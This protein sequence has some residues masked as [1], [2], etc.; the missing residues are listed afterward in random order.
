MGGEAR[1]QAARR[2]R[3]LR[4]H[5]ARTIGLLTV[6]YAGYYLCRSNLSVALPEIIDELVASGTSPDEARIHLGTIVS[7][8]VFAYAVGKLCL[9]GTADLLGGR[10]NF[11][12]GMGGAVAF[13]LLF[14]SGGGLPLFTLAWIGN[15]TAQSIGWAGIVKVTSRWFSYSSYGAVMGAVSL[16]YLFG[17][18]LAR[19]ALSV[20]IAQGFGWR[21]VFRFAAAGLALLLLANWRWLRESRE[22]LGFAPPMVH[23]QSLFRDDEPT[24]RHVGE[25]LRPLLHDRSFWMVCLL[26]LGCTLLRETFNTWIP[27]Y[28]HEAAGYSIADAAATSALFPFVGGVSVVVAG[29]V[30]DRLGTTG[31]EWVIVVGLALVTVALG[32]LGGVPSDVGPRSAVGMVLLVAFALLGPY[33]YLAG[34]IALELGGR[35]GSATSSAVIDGVGYM[36]GVLAGDSIARISAAWGWSGAFR[37]LAAVAALSA[38]AAA[39]LLAIRRQSAEAG[40]RDREA[41][42][43]A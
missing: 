16:S 20:L 23:P 21:A 8:G 34:A 14:A 27:T 43:L 37:A 30:G 17:D 36:G 38:V 40:R 28:L 5:Q 29:I 9:G 4:V 25:I 24:P 13:T 3:A 39:G 11:L 10:R 42:R 22:E 18:A 19:L 2:Q 1:T 33:S 15:R 31:R 35:D 41:S 12:A 26:S 7:L 32:V 6:G